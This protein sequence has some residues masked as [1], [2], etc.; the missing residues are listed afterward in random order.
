MTRARC[1]WQLWLLWL[2]ALPGLGCQANRIGPP[3]SALLGQG[4]ADQRSWTWFTLLRDEGR[5][6]ARQF[7]KRH[8]DDIGRRE[9]LDIQ[10]IFR[11]QQKPRIRVRAAAKA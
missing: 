4:S 9:T 6:S 3:P 5:A 2:G 10:K 1:C 7:L 11:S 8:L